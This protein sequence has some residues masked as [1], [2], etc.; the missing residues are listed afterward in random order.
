MTKRRPVDAFL[1]LVVGLLV[2]IGAVMVFS[3]SS[4]DGI[5][6][7]HDAAYFLK[8]EI[9]WI[10]IGGAAALVGLNMDYCRLRAAA[11][12][13]F[14][15]A[16]ALLGLVLV[17]HLGSMEGG[18]QRWFAFKSFSFEPSEFAKLAVVVM[19][20]R[21]FADREDGALS[22]GRAGFPA[23][24]CVGICF[25]LVMREPD[26]GTASLFVITAAVMLFVAG[27]KW[28]HL[29]IGLVAAVPTLL[30][31]V[32]SSAY[33]RDRFTAF[34]HPWND[35]TDTGYHIIQS[36]YALGSGGWLGL[37]LGESRQKFGYL[38]EQYTDFIYAIIGEELGFIGAAIVLALFLLLLYRGIRIAMNA[39]DRFGVY[40]AVGITASIVLQALVNIGVAG[41]RRAAALHLLW[42]H[43]ARHQHVRRRRARR[44]LARSI[45]SGSGRRHPIARG[46][47]CEYCSPAAAPA[48]I[49]T[50]CCHS[51]ERSPARP[52]TQASA[53]RARPCR[54]SSSHSI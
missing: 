50:P 53:N 43:V 22:F 35:P 24:L 45:A 11:P 46:K 34:L 51:P 17:P 23:L 38:P 49:C 41:H 12:W 48:V 15:V 30:L 28:Q 4:V 29:F 6:Q 31:F 25:V 39:D 3:A 37:G 27:A 21:I 40:L 19:L 14:G 54:R 20:A 32:Y 36:L 52:L 8:R 13:I 47:R 2:A 7:F 9:L 18:A 16:V 26:F 5:T 44:H 33:R 10:A 42:R 1:L